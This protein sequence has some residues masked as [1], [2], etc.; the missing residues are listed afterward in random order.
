MRRLTDL[1][2]VSH[3]RREGRSALSPSWV[4]H[5]LTLIN[6]AL[7]VERR[8]S[9]RGEVIVDSLDGLSLFGNTDG[10]VRGDI[11]DSSVIGDDEVV[12]R[13]DGRDTVPTAC[14]GEFLSKTTHS[15]IISCTLSIVFVFSPGMM[16]NDGADRNGEEVV[17]SEVGVR[18]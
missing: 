15:E 11:D 3:M 4:S 14:V 13:M 9:I 18:D 1:A 12:Q 5:T 2:S 8:S 10:C 7:G 17:I 6:F 16:D